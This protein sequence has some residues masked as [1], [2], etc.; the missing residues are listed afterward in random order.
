MQLGLPTL[1]RACLARNPHCICLKLD[2]LLNE[3]QIQHLAVLKASFS[4]SALFMEQVLPL[5]IAKC[6]Y[7][8]LVIQP[9][10]NPNLPLGCTKTT[11]GSLAIYIQDDDVLVHKFP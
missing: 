4:P 2:T 5:S 9:A 3:T 10:H 1:S 6:R 8:L 11:S 7:C